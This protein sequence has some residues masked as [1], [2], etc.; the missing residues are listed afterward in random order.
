MRSDDP[1][2][3]PSTRADGPSD[4]SGTNSS[5]LIGVDIGGTFTDAAA[6]DVRSGEATTAKA[7]STPSDLTVGVIDALEELA[8]KLGVADVTALLNR[9]EKFAHGTTRTSNIMFTWSGART[10]L[11]TT[12]GFAD[13]L[14]IMRARGRVA[15]V[16]LAS[17]RHFRATEK[18]PQIVPRDLIE[19]VTERVD[20]HGTAIV[21]LTRSE[22]E[23]AVDALLSRDVEAVAISLLWAQENPEHEQL[24]EAVLRERAPHIYVSV[25]HRVAPVL[26]EYERTATTAVNAYV[27]PTAVSYVKQLTAELESRGLR[28][29]ILIVQANGGVARSDAALPV[30]TI[31]SGPAAAMAA[32]RDAAHRMGHRNLIAT[33]VGGTTFKVGLLVDGEWTYARETVIN[34]YTLTVP[35][36]DLVSI[37]A[38]GGSIAWVDDARLRIGPKSAG[39]E[40]GPACYGLGGTEP[41]V[42]DADLVLGFLNPDR[43]LGGRLRLDVEAARQAVHVG[44]A[45]GLF[46]GDVV[47]AAS[48]IRDVVDAQ[49]A[50][51]VRRMTIERGYDPRRFALMAYGGAGPLHAASYARGLGVTQVVIPPG[52]T[53]YSAFGAAGSDLQHFAQRSVPSDEAKDPAAVER[54]FDEL[55]RDCLDLLDSQGITR[56]RIKLSRWAEMRYERQLHDVRIEVPPGTGRAALLDVMRRAFEERYAAL[57]GAGAILRRANTRLLRVGVTATA[58]M[59]RPPATA[60]ALEPSDPGPA[61]V[62]TRPVFWSERDG[63]SSTQ[64]FDGALLRPGHELFG[65]AVIEHWGTTIAV[66]ADSKATI[67]A[68]GNTLIAV[69]ETR[70]G[71]S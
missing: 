17:R 19:E 57:Y 14:L 25:G 43:F 65:P 59:R 66:P 12:R 53:A 45:D 33:D 29:P 55:S 4:R 22:A 26:G 47:R 67:D 28:E 13:E 62:G 68:F 61:L 31:E 9:T 34:Q 40:P 16:S 49:M 27:G 69:A 6:I 10:G 5:L 58:A 3:R 70:K 23:R 60:A 52:A 37:G 63:W 36:I 8:S 50:G 21:P 35:M 54:L 42:T 71:T 7:R 44:V 48:G 51:L 32:V 20:H 56:G 18:P 41:T 15:G 11:L 46:G 64:V 39:A 2:P 38:G 24:L 30:A 1:S